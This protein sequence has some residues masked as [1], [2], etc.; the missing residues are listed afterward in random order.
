MAIMVVN[1]SIY[2]PLSG[3]TAPPLP[4]T[5]VKAKVAAESHIDPDSEAGQLLR[6]AEENRKLISR[7][8]ELTTQVKEV[9]EQFGTEKDRVAQQWQDRI[10][11]VEESNLRKLDELRRSTEKDVAEMKKNVAQVFDELRGKLGGGGQMAIQPPPVPPF[12]EDMNSFDGGRIGQTKEVPPD[13]PDPDPEKENTRRRD[14]VKD[15][16]LHSWRAYKKYAWGSDELAPLSQHGKDWAKIP[17]NGIGVTI[18]DALST[19]WLMGLKEEFDEAIQWVENS[20]NWDREADV[21]QFESTIRLVAGLLS[22][23]ELSGEQHRFLVD[24]AADLVNRLLFAYNTTTGIPKST[25]NLNSRAASNPRW[26]GGSSILS[27]F[28][29][30]Q[31]ELRTLTYHTGNGWYDKKGTAIM[32]Y[33]RPR[34]PPDGLPPT[35]FNAGNGRWANDHITL[36]AMG[37]S[38]YEYLLKQWVLTGKMEEKYKNMWLKAAEGITSRLVQKSNPSG[39]VYIAEFKRGGLYHKMDHLACFAAGMF[40]LAAH[41]MPD[42]DEASKWSQLAADLTAT[43]HLMYK[44]TRTGVSPEIAEFRNGGDMTPGAPYYIL[45][46]E[47]VES[48]FYQWRF[49]KEQQYR[50]WGWEMFRHVNHWCRVESGGFSGLKN[51]NMFPPAQDDLMQSFWLAET[52]KYL[53]LLFS[54]DD[55]LD[56]SQWVINTEAHPLKIRPKPELEEDVEPP[57]LYDSAQAFGGGGGGG[58]EEVASVIVAPPGYR[59]LRST[60][61]AGNDFPKP[62]PNADPMAMAAI[63]NADPKCKGFNSNGWLKTSVVHTEHQRGCDLFIKL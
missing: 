32:D 53:Y 57:S 5:A 50:D 37:D 62:H 42:H 4:E 39:Q 52:L 8:D 55:A 35:Y 23:Y 60:D 61:A 49:T 47:T 15:A 48:Y 18:L 36:G 22:A 25:V 27:E 19:L 17:G 58:Y 26:A 46:P 30:V 11:A 33:I 41:E 9:L 43:C 38:Y 51:V 40:G 28:G 31:L 20:L 54:E 21:S 13:T 45:R 63:C 16:F 14:A 24:K 29:T 3:S 10:A 59:V 12:P 1:I 34:L 6:L 2:L 44:T 7:V 56:L